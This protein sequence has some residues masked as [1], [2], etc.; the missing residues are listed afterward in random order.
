MKSL[1]HNPIF[2]LAS[3]SAFLCATAFSAAQQEAIP[4]PDAP[5]TLAPARSPAPSA[6]PDLSTGLWPTP[7]LLDA[8]VRRVA[9]DVAQQYALSPSQALEV[10]DRMAARWG[11]FFQQNRRDLQPLVNEYLETRFAIEPPDPDRVAE[12]AAR[13]LPVFNRLRQNV[14]AGELE[15]RDMLDES[16]RAA[17]DRTRREH[18]LGMAALEGQLKRWSVG[19]FRESE[20]W[21]PPAGHAQDVPSSARADVTG[22]D[23][24]GADA[25]G[26]NATGDDTT[27]SSDPGAAHNRDAA[28]GRT[29]PNGPPAT[30]DS[31]LPPRVA[32]ELAA[33][34]KFTA[35][36]C[37]RH[38]LDRS[39][40][41]AADSI[42]RELLTR[43]HDHVRRNRA[44]IDALEQRIAAGK[45]ETAAV[46]KDADAEDADFERNL[47]EL[48]GPLDRMF[49]ELAERLDKLPTDH[50]RR[51]A[52]TPL[53]EKEE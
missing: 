48:Y 45:T 1:R 51:Q 5:P 13:A 8:L 7:R 44:R 29:G 34:E 36:F 24:T 11:E 2:R 23:A 3:V 20:W 35:D 47:V 26:D 17:F 22:T 21:D 42:L 39:Q 14:E 15:V 19:K 28:N 25:T 53:P 50:Q 43:A 16:Q 27:E 9:S 4:I 46:A 12:W 52:A 37:D 33:W 32:E 40:R 38:Q 18:Q 31:Q 10:E 41:N 49:A 30:A 6:E